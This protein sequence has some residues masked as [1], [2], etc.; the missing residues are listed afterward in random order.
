MTVFLSLYY[1]SKYNGAWSGKTHRRTPGLQGM[2]L[3]AAGES[4]KPGDFPALS[5]RNKIPVLNCKIPPKE[6]VLV[7]STAGHHSDLL[8]NS[9]GE[10][11]C[12]SVSCCHSFESTAAGKTSLLWAAPLQGPSTAGSSVPGH[13]A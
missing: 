8:S 1:D 12:W 11:S 10:H 5:E 6:T 13:S 4:S 7:A 9:C 2:C 3:R